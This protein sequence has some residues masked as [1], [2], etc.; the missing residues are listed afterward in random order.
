M[1]CEYRDSLGKPGEGFHEERIGDFALWDILGTIIIIIVLSF[2]TNTNIVYM[3]I[4]VSL[5][6]I[7]LHRIF[8]V[9]TALNVKIFGPV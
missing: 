9:N 5:L 3:T 2:V 7:F 1:F 4:F 6:T 8:C